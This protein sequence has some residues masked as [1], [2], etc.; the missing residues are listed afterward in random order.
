[1][2]RPILAALGFVVLGWSAACGSVHHSEYLAPE[3]DRARVRSAAVL[4]LENLTAQPEAGKV[5]ADAIADSLAAHK[6]QVVD[7]GRSEAALAKVDVVPGGTIDRLA[8]QRLGEIL[9]VDAVVFGSV[10]EAG[11]SA[12]AGPQSLGV[13]VRMVDV[14]TGNW[15]LAGSYSAKGGD[16]IG[17]A[18]SKAAEAVGKAVGK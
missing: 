11:T 17:G 13:S 3:A 5:V 10:A 7:R 16:S 9:G 12:D 2:K 14:K 18:A 15:L 6:L 8:A 1:M 4:P